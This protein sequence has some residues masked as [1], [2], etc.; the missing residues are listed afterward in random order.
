MA[1]YIPPKG[2]APSPPY[3]VTSYSNP[4]PAPGHIVNLFPSPGPV[5]PLEP[6]PVTV[7]FLQLPGVPS[8]LEFLIQIDQILIHQKIE[9][10]KAFFG[11][12]ICNRYELHSGAGILLG[13]AVEESSCCARLCCGARRPMRIRVA[14]PRN[15]EVL[16]LIRPLHCGSCSC[17]CCLQELEVQAPPGTTVGHVL[18]TWHPFL[19]KFSIQDADRQTLLRVVGPCCAC[20]CG[21]DTNF[22]VK[23]K[24]ESRSVGRISK[25]WGGIVPEAL[26]DADQFGLQFPLDLDV[27]LKAVLL[28]AAFL[29]VRKSCFPTLPLAKTTMTMF[30][31]SPK[32]TPP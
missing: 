24:D 12:D 13:Q 9:R 29:I 30:T 2:Y 4:A 26:T 17:P 23:T 8:G 14:D 19:P 6:E 28:G 1:G 11:W 25:Q 5:A 15:R 32:R 22:E 20:G 18:Q 16:H 7:P 21:S 27:R 3:P 10:V 31:P